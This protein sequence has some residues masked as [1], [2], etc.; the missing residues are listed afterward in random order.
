MSSQKK[1]GNNATIFG[2]GDRLE[3]TTT[4]TT[5]NERES[6]NIEV[7]KEEEEFRLTFND[8]ALPE[9]IVFGSSKVWIRV[10]ISGASL[11]DSLGTVRERLS[12]TSKV[13]DRENGRVRVAV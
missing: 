3:E 12:D 1:R 2:N 6:T 13:R 7:E 10:S 8:L 4:T 9:H 11:G 5:I